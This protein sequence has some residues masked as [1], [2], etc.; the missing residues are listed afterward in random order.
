MKKVFFLVFMYVVQL[1]ATPQF[2]KDY[3]VSCSTCHSAIPVLNETGRKFLRDGLRFSF[4]EK[5]TWQRFTE[6]SNTTY[7]PATLVVSVKYNSV[8]EDVKAAVKPFFAATLTNEDS[9]FFS[10]GKTK[11]IYYQKNLNKQNHVLRGGFLSVYTQLSSIDKIFSVT[12]IAS[13]N[14]DC[15]SVF[16]TPLQK[17]SI[18]SIKGIDYSYKRGNTMMLLSLGV[19]QDN[20][21]RKNCFT[22]YDLDYKDKTQ[23]SAAIKHSI[24]G[25]NLGFIYGK[26]KDSDMTDYSLLS[27]LD[28]DFE[29]IS[30]HLAYVYKKDKS[31]N[32]QGVESMLSYRYDDTLFF[33]TA[34]S[35]DNDEFFN[36][37][38]ITIGFEKVYK[39]F[40]FSCYVGSRENMDNRESTFQTSVSMYF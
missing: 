28:K 13:N 40:I 31:F 10:F 8:K 39:H 2:A 9:I 30:L 20:T 33:K 24:Y 16:K 38:S 1:C 22:S 12:G 34:G 37:S 21:R 35:Y 23:I 26:I 17:A 18:Q 6:D 5:T 36:N 29:V 25:Y 19:T 32:Y 4:H 15:T 27:F 11:N 7:I 14:D 3:D